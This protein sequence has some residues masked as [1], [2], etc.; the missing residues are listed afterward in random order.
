[1][2]QYRPT[3]TGVPVS[4]LDAFALL[5]VERARADGADADLYA[6]LAYVT[7][8]G[9]YVDGPSADMLRGIRARHE[10]RRRR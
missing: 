7:R 4:E 5:E 6:L 1:M 9:G 3:G 10:E 8:M 2:S